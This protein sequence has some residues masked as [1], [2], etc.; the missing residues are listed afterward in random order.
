MRPTHGA[1]GLAGV[2]A[3][4]P[5]LDAAGWFAPD[6]DLLQRVGEALLPPERSGPLGLLLRPASV[7]LN[8][9]PAVADALSRA[10]AKL[11][12]AFGRP[13]EIRIAHEGL[14]RLH[15]C[16]RAVQAQEAW[17]TLGGWVTAERPELEPAVAE[18]LRLSASL[19]PAEA[20]AARAWRRVLQARLWALLDGGAALVFPTSPCPA[21]RVDADAAELARVREAAIGA[22]AIASLCGLP[23]VTLPAARVGGAPVGLSLVAGR[24]RDRALLA[25][26]REIADV[27]ELPKGV[28]G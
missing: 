4:A 17:A 5:S 10:V 15:D 20:A 23:E 3:L 8:A 12:R 14:G 22:T 25:F 21:P 26:A 18:R 16:Y 19:D 2:R 28:Q 11:D 27:L 13:S 24:G 7:W 1:V 9:D 6:A